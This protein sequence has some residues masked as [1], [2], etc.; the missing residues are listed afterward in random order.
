MRDWEIVV[1]ACTIAV[2]LWIVIGYLTPIL[3]PWRRLV[4]QYPT[5]QWS[6]SVSKARFVS[7]ECGWASYGNCLTI[8]FGEDAMT[9]RM[10]LMLL[11]FHPPFTVPKS[12]IHHVRRGRLMFIDWIKFQV[13]DCQFL[14]WGPNTRT[15]FFDGLE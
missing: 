3:G 8:D 9:V 2:I 11:P 15:Q 6:P 14:L 13:D 12:A 1:F 5:H 7:M 10:G 4:R